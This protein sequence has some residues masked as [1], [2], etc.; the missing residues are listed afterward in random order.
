MK[1]TLAY[2]QKLLHDPKEST[3]IL[4]IFQRFLDI[5]GLI[6]QDFALLFGDATSAKLL[7][8]W[9]TNI[10][11]KVIEQSRG[12]TQTS[13]LQDLIQNAEAT[14]VEEGWDSDMSS[15]LMMVHLLPPSSQ[16][17]KRLGK[18]SARQ[19]CDRLMKFIKTSTS[20]QGH[21]DSTGESL[22]PYLLAVGPKRSRIHSWFIV[23]EEHALPCKASN[24]L[25]CVDELF[26]AHFVFGTS[27]C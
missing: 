11:P 19:A 18:I 8:K 4:A 15:I 26:K 20:I 25:A 5:P 17:R 21:L 9:S 1:L 27:Y 23:I 10:K 14:E 2:R 6:D 13:E 12:L 24:S 3:D 7:E 22:Q 16:G